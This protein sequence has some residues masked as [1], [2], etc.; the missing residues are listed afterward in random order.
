MTGLSIINVRNR[1]ETNQELPRKRFFQAEVYALHKIN[2]TNSYF[3]RF[4]GLN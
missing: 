3:I 4:P 1:L 2:F